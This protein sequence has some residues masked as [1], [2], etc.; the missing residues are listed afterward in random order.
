MEA[1]VKASI[2]SRK[3]SFEMS[4]ELTDDAR[5]DIDELFTRIEEF[6]NSCKDAMDF[7]AKFASSPLNQEYIDM[8]TKIAKKCKVK[9]LDT[10]SDDSKGKRI[11]KEAGSDAKYLADDLTM[12]ARRQARMKFDQKMRSTPLGKIEQANNTMWLFKRLKHKVS[13]KDDIPEDESSKN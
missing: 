10:S 12:P 9:G 6:G 2:D 8:F 4:Y 7:E 3:S 1:S 13:K 5:K 11:L